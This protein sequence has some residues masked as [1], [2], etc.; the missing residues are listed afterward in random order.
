VTFAIEMAL[1]HVGLADPYTRTA[2]HCLQGWPRIVPAPR[3]TVA[4]PKGWQQ[5]KVG[6]TGPRLCTLIRTRMSSGDSLAYS[7]NTS[8]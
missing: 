8:K 7:T 4:E 5:M 2:S 1:T 3:P 6:G